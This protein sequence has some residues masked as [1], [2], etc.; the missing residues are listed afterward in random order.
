M[1]T[2][3]ESTPATIDTED[4][5]NISEE[6]RYTPAVGLSGKDVSNIDGVISEKE[7]VEE[8]AK[9][10]KDMGPDELV[11]KNNNFMKLKD[12]FSSA[13]ENAKNKVT[14]ATKELTNSLPKFKI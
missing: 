4:I 9:S 1:T 3:N 10:E 12:M 2:E 8:D 14:T 7:R 6:G 13:R 11:H 5:D